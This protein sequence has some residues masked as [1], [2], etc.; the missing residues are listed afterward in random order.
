MQ[1]L[2]DD[3]PE[4]VAMLDESCTIVAVNRSWSQAMAMYG[5][6]GTEPGGNYRRACQEIAATGYEPASKVLAAIDR[7]LAG[8]RSYWQ[9]IFNG[10]GQW[11]S[12]QYQLSFHRVIVAGRPFIT[13]SRFDLTEILELRKMKGEFANS[14]NEGRIAERRRMARELH[15]STSQQLAAMGL[16]LGRL[17][18]QSAAHE[19]LALVEEI[20][21]LVR[22]AHQ[23]IRS[24]SYLAHPPALERTQFAD[25]LKLLV[26]G[27]GRRTGL[28]ASFEI[29][30]DP[31]VLPELAERAFYRVAQEALTNVYRHSGA[32]H[33]RLRLSFRGATGHLLIADDG[34]GI[35]KRMLAAGD[36]GGVGIPSMRS[37][38]AEIGGRL[39]IRSSSPGT[40][41]IATFMS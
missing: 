26:E 24:I 2:I 10:R 20:E 28:E 33:V 9:I 14:L 39:S 31:L 6:S 19:T 38:L 11:S 16:L 27:F 30:G 21:E 36:H 3:L 40:A 4:Q 18:R 23:E 8:T 35:S 34:I 1:Q 15:D 5:Y 41:I 32:S 13:I 22:E 29:Q 17:K 12:R 25:A 7:I 37:R